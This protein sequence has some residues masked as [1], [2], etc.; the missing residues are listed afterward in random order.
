MDNRKM[1][2]KNTALLLHDG[3]F[4]NLGVGIPTLISEYVPSNITILLHGETGYIGQ[5]RIIPV[6]KDEVNEWE[7]KHSGE[8]GNW[9]I[10]HKDLINAGCQ[11]IT[12]IPGASCFDSSISFAMARGGHLDTTILGALQV[13]EEG[14]LANWAVPGKTIKGMGGAMDLVNGAKRVIIAMEHCTKSGEAKILKK[15]TMPLTAIRCVNF[16]VTELCVLECK[17]EG[18]HVLAMAP[19]LSQEEL[20]KKTKAT[21]LFSNNMEEMLFP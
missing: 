6:E 9:K 5:N 12:L 20:K 3:E 8:R 13:D 15:C 2:A 14:N 21:L 18:F 19:G 10:G 17:E 11:N 16:V 1:I 4:V 7:K